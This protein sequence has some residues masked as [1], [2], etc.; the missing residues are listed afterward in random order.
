MTL[1]TSAVSQ[2]ARAKLE[3][4]C[5]R[6][7]EATGAAASVSSIDGVIRGSFSTAAAS[8]GLPLHWLCAASDGR[9]S[10]HRSRTGPVRFSMAQIVRGSIDAAA[11]K[12]A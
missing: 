3:Q 7:I 4:R 10:P 9:A 12:C 1:V 6:V 5:D 2:R 8:E 11:H